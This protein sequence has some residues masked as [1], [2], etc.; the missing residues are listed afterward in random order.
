[1]LLLIGAC[2]D[3]G[4]LVYEFMPNGSLEDRL[5]R[6]NNTPAIPWP[7]RFRIA[8]EVASALAFLHS[9]NPDP[10][11]HRDLKPSNILLDSNL[12][13]KIADLGLATTLDSNSDSDQNPVGTMSYIDPE[14]QR[15]GQVSPES[16]VYALGV[17]V[18]QLLTAKPAIALVHAVET[19]FGDGRLAEVLDGEAGDWPADETRELA[20]LGLG[21]AELRRCDRPDLRDRVLPALQRLKEAADKARDSASDVDRLKPPPPPSHFICPILKV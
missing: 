7:D 14:Y 13:S 6:K 11:V 8:F 1:M 21:C 3:R 10:I 9:S 19:A 4:C 20:Q 18:L 5:S 17:V 15:T 16:D 12:V 2:P